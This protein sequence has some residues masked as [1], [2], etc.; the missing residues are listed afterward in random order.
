MLPWAR[1]GWLYLCCEFCDKKT[2]ALLSQAPSNMKKHEKTIMNQNELTNLHEFSWIFYTVLNIYM[3]LYVFTMT[4]YGSSIGCFCCVCLFFLR[5][6]DSP[7]PCAAAGH[8]LREAG[9]VHNLVKNQSLLAPYSFQIQLVA[10]PS[11]A[12]VL[13]PENA[14][15]AFGQSLNNRGSTVG[16]VTTLHRRLA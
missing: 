8:W 6:W 9:G 10:D 7:C 1:Y 5:R 2:M 14:A 13:F 16:V 3:Y 15:Q 11:C 12:A 4:Y